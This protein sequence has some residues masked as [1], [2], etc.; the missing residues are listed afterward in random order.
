[1]ARIVSVTGYPY[2]TTSGDIEVPDD[3]KDEEL[4]DYIK[5]HFDEI[6]F[7]EPDLDYCGTDF[8]F[9]TD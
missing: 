6:S 4:H 2:A 7:G 9:Y 1:M 5:E 8:E 3:V